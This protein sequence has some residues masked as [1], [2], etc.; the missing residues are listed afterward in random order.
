SGTPPSAARPQVVSSAVPLDLPPSLAHEFK[1]FVVIVRVVELAGF[2][3]DDSTC[4]TIARSG[5]RHCEFFVVIPFVQRQSLFEISKNDPI[6]FV[7]ERTAFL[8]QCD[9]LSS[10]FG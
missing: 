4:S 8:D 2:S 6:S 10:F 1:G 3:Q 7:R 5:R 9:R